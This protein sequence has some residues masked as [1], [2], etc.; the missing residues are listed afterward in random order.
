MCVGHVTVVKRDRWSSRWLSGN[1][2]LLGQALEILRWRLISDRC[3]D[4]AGVFGTDQ[5]T[6]SVTVPNVTCNPLPAL[7]LTS[8]V[9][10]VA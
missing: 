8:C 7:L 6:H 2:M 1:C 3:V 10:S 9:V 4:F 5:F